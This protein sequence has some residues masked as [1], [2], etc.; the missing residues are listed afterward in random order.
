LPSANPAGTRQRFFIFYFK[1]FLCRVPTL[2]ALGKDFLFFL[3]KILCRVPTL[4]SAKIFYFFYKISLPSANP[5]GTRQRFFV[6][7][8][9]IICRVPLVRRSAKFELPSALWPALGKV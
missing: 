5:S 8:K 6:F 1:K 3:K 2:Q 4:H 7:L 9:K